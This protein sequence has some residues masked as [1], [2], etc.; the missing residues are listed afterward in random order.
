MSKLL[1][2]IILARGKR[3]E[4]IHGDLTEEQVDVIVNAANQWLQHGA[5]VAGAIIQKGGAVIQS[6]SNEWVAKH[7]SITRD[8]PAYTNAGNLPCRYV[9]HAVG[10]VWGE[11][12]EE[13]KLYR[14]IMGALKL[15]VQLK[16]H[17]L[18]IPPISTGIFGFPKDKAAPIFYSAINN[19]WLSEP[20]YLLTKIRITIIDDLTSNVFLTALEKWNKENH[21]DGNNGS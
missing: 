15:A 18:S 6:E 2:Y 14:A 7:G 13:E 12:E 10:P 11:G 16:A 17:T 3:M 9:I 20:N 5:G 19:F 8:Q 1:G 21:T 4:L